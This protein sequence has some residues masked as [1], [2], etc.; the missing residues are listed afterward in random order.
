[1]DAL[2]NRALP[3]DVAAQFGYADQPHLT[4]SLRRLIGQTPARVAE[5]GG[6][7][8]A[9]SPVGGSRVAP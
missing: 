1:V 6:H 4:R 9:S 5:T 3:S 8:S 7:W 2:G